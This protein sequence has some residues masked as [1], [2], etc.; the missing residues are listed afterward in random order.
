MIARRRSRRRRALA[1][2][3]CLLWLLGVEVLPNLHLATHDE[4]APH[5]HTASGLIVTVSFGETTHRHADG[6]VHSH[7]APDGEP[8]DGEPANERANDA[9]A[10]ELP[11]DLHV[12][13]GLAHRELALHDPPPPDLDPVAP[14]RLVTLAV[15]LA[16]D[17]PALEAHATAS[18]RGPP[19]TR[20]S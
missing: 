10:I 13:A 6:S 19:T 8:A 15:A 4:S 12:A 5:T 9:L 14:T 1:A 18:A 2:I 7:A 20:R 3:A 17:H 16:D 11:P